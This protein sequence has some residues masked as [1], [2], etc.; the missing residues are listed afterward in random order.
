MTWIVISRSMKNSD[1]TTA[2]QLKR[3]GKLTEAIAAYKK[4]ISLNP[5]FYWSYHNLGETFAQ[6]SQYQAAIEAYEQAIRLNPTAAWSYYQL[7]LAWAQQEQWQQAITAY[8]QAIEIN[9]HPFNFYRD[10]GEALAKTEK[11]TEAIQAYLKAIEINP[12]SGKI[13]FNLAE[14]LIKMRQ[15][16]A[17]INQLEKAIKLKPYHSKFKNKLMALRQQDHSIN[18]SKNGAGSLPVIIVHHHIFKC[19]G[20]TLA[21]ILQKNFPNQ[22]LHIESVTP[23]S[24]ITC[25]D[26]V[27]V[28][29]DKPHYQAV[30]SH[31]LTLPHPGEE[32]GHIHISLLR[33]P[34]QR[35]LSEY[36][37]EKKRKGIQPSL[38][39]K[40]Y[41]ERQLERKSNFQVKHSSLQDE[42][43]FQN[44]QGWSQNLETLDLNRD[45]LFFGIVEQFD[46][47][48]VVL[49][50]LFLLRGITFDAAYDAV[51]N[52]SKRKDKNAPLP[53]QLINWLR[54][55]NQLD[56]KFYEQCK[57]HLQQQYQA[58]DPTGQ[59]LIDFR[60]RC[61]KISSIKQTVSMPNHQEWV[62]IKRDE[63]GQFIKK[64]VSLDQSPSLQEIRKKVSNLVSQ[65]QWD[66]AVAYLIERLQSNPHQLEVYKCLGEVFEKQG[67]FS[68]AAQFYQGKISLQTLEKFTSFKIRSKIIVTSNSASQTQ[69]INI[70]PE[71]VIY[72][73]PPKILKSPLHPSFRY[74]SAKIPATFVAIIPNGRG[75]LDGQN[76][77]IIN[78]KNQ[79]L[80][81]LSTGNAELILSSKTLPPIDEINGTVCSLVTP[82]AGKGYYHWMVALLP[83]LELVRRSGIDLNTIDKFLVNHYQ[84]PFQFETLQKMG[85]PQDKIMDIQGRFHIRAKKLIVPNIINHWQLQ[86]EEIK[87]NT[88][89]HEDSIFQSIR[90]Q[91]L[92]KNHHEF[93]QQKKRIYITRKEQKSRKI[94]NEP[95]LVDLLKK[96]KFEIVTLEHLSV[97]QQ[98]HL[99]AQAK[100]VIAPHG[101]GLSN[102]IFCQPGTQVIEFFSSHI[103]PYYWLLCNDLSLEYYSLYCQEFKL[104]QPDRQRMKQA[105]DF[106]MINQ[107]NIT[108]N[109]ESFVQILELAN[110]S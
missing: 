106:L 20:T 43:D 38:T 25:S 85:I 4:A 100:V 91:F 52:T 63:K 54:E 96:L 48:M 6:L 84:H 31:L 93:E 102:L 39:F 60:E 49:E 11:F 66:K 87:L 57:S 67:K 73:T 1:F 13:Y 99:M 2:N 55:K 97:S 17:A 61:S 5:E 23:A 77:V 19:A 82:G 68:D 104:H 92:S 98:A 86:T 40:E 65:K 90:K 103:K 22:V 21:W 56:F 32:I 108:V 62:R 51:K 74:K 24:R 9:P 107:S 94:L 33:D 27:P 3:Q 95:D 46:Q 53:P 75:W 79:V 59:K 89:D 18:L 15:V 42:Q 64:K 69:R 8:S 35:M 110:I 81:D 76:N 83:R 16:K 7:G 88:S 45:S 36:N 50:H 41:C 29:E 78:S 44:H 47:S 30:S 105:K 37:F 101:A 14:I 34:I 72:L 70:D 80:K 109:L 10:L 71:K 58:I 12:E 28:L 26:L